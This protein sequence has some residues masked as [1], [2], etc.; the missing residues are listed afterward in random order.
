[1]PKRTPVPPL[2]LS[3]PNAPGY[4]ALRMGADWASAVR[5][6]PLRLRY[7]PET[8][9]MAIG[10]SKEPGLT[11]LT[12]TYAKRPQI[13]KITFEVEAALKGGRKTA[14]I[15]LQG[16]TAS[17][18]LWGESAVEKFMVSYYAEAAGENAARFLGRL[19][20]AWYFYP[21]NVVQV[22][23]MV[24]LCGTK[25]PPEGTRLSLASTVGLI[26]L[27]LASGKLRLL[28][29]DEYTARYTPQLPRDAQLPPSEL[30]GE[31]ERGWHM[32][33]EVESIIARDCAEFVSGL[34]GRFVTFLTEGQELY[35]ELSPTGP[36]VPPPAPQGT[37]QF[38]AVMSP[39]RG[40][41]PA[42]IRVT[43]RV[44]TR[45]GKTH[46]YDVVP[47]GDNPADIP[48]S[49]FW[50]DGGVEKFML[51][52]YGSVKGWAA[53]IYTSLLMAKW[54]G[55]V[56]ADE[57]DLEAGL[58]AMKQLLPKS[59]GDIFAHRLDE[60]PDSSL[61]GLVHLPRSE[62]TSSPG[63]ALESR[64]VF[65]AASGGG[66]V[67]HALHNAPMPQ[68]GAKRSRKSTSRAR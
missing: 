65:L 5:D 7:D 32:G 6:V 44:K 50:S 47:G 27:E 28:T 59:P 17:A 36:P 4:A 13:K 66:T 23:A 43:A 30:P 48:D 52:Y 24:Y 68:R 31:R 63:M 35:P 60:D 10:G 15:E 22:C 2:P 42:P 18:L 51:P 57:I 12:K 33:D 56:A 58:E 26:C 34:R 39:V 20:D 8:G 29:L 25:A 62:Y 14:S 67:R 54:A 16:E 53:P 3:P 55:L 45:H 61:Y 64:T 1:M 40:D 19:S 41:R 9:H 46:D 38:A 37:F 49:M 21:S 11:V